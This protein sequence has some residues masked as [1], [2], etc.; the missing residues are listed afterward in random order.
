MPL[1]LLRRLIPLADKSGSPEVVS[2]WTDGGWTPINVKDWGAKGDGVTDDSTAIQLAIN[3]ASLVPGGQDPGSGIVLYFPPGTYLVKS[4]LTIGAKLVLQ[5]S[6]VEGTVILFN[7]TVPGICIN[8]NVQPLRVRFGFGCRDIA[9]AGQSPADGQTLF[10]LTNCMGMRFENVEFGGVGSGGGVGAVFSDTVAAPISQSSFLLF[11]HCFW[12]NCRNA[13]SN[14]HSSG[15]TENLLFDHCSF[16]ANT[17]ATGAGDFGVQIAN[18][19]ADV[20]FYQC[21]FDSVRL[22]VSGGVVTSIACHYEDPNNILANTGLVSQTGGLVTS[23]G[24]FFLT[25]STTNAIWSCSAGVAQIHGVWSATGVNASCPAF[26]IVTGTGTV[27]V[28]LTS[29]PGPNVTDLFATTSTGN[30]GVVQPI[31]ASPD[32]GDANVA[33]TAGVDAATQVFNS[34][35][36]ANRTVTLNTTGHAFGSRFRIVRTAAATGA[37]TLTVG[38]KTLALGQEIEMEFHKT[39][40]WIETAFSTL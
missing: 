16:S 17:D 33:V 19:G 6:T 24:D 25:Q 39:L 14:F 1:P 10:Q 13:F 8:W 12:S 30:C 15:S 26:V 18:P 11:R 40:G 38:A 35:L 7:L 2:D 31:F 27:T 37:F 5:G 4:P 34:P 23:I 28:G 22:N 9:F 3:Q 36:T 32:R 29:L 20:H 21:S